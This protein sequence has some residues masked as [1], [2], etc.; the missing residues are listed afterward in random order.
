MCRESA[1]VLQ[2]TRYAP[3]PGSVRSFPVD[4]SKR[5]EQVPLRDI[6]VSCNEPISQY[7]RQVIRF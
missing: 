1:P 5:Q 4:A 2:V 7:P 6:N 3:P